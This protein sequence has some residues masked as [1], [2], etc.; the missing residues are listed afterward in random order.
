MPIP[1]D[2]K[3]QQKCDEARVIEDDENIHSRTQKQVN[4]ILIEVRRLIRDSNEA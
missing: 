1:R 4:A 2:V 3:L